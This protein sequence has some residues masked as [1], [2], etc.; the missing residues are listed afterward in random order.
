MLNRLPDP[1]KLRDKKKTRVP[2]DDLCNA[3]DDFR[4][5]RPPR[6]RTSGGR[7]HDR[8]RRERLRRSAERGNWSAGR[9]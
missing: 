6:R 7:I 1:L 5:S 3:H 4:S 2:I 9:F 8:I